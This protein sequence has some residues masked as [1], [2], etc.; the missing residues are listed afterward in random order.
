[1]EQSVLEENVIND[2]VVASDI[3]AISSEKATDQPLVQELTTDG[4]PL[5]SENE[6]LVNTGNSELPA[7]LNQADDGAAGVQEEIPAE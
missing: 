7:D 5:S 3:Q 2:E 1:V 6:L 4:E